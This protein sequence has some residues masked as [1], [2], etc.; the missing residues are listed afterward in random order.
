MSE[1]PIGTEEV[2]AFQDLFVPPHMVQIPLEEYRR[3]IESMIKGP[4]VE[5]PLEEYTRLKMENESLR[6]ELGKRDFENR[7]LRTEINKRAD[8]ESLISQEC[9]RIVEEIKRIVTDSD[10]KETVSGWEVRK[11]G[12]G[13][14]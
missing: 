9:G 2:K 12:K 10:T 14:R 5:I 4:T 13:K 6:H 1:K 11:D 8:A 7:E 3:Y